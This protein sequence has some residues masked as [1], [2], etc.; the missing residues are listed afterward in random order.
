MINQLERCVVLD[1]Q[2]E[3][4]ELPAIINPQD[5]RRFKKCRV[6]VVNDEVARLFFEHVRK[7]RNAVVVVDELDQY[8][9]PYDI[10][11]NLQWIIKYGR[12]RNISFIGASR[13][14][15][16]IHRDITANINKLHCFRITEPLDVA[17]LR[18][19]SIPFSQR[20]Q[21]LPDFHYHTL[22]L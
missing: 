2:N 3:Y 19:L 9:T 7:M 21:S 20:V 11:E 13:R 8:C 15:A 16:E 12:H 14:P 6:I 4:K 18:K 10:D 5:L 22:K 1:Y 17:Y